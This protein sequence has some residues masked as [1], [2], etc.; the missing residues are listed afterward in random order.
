MVFI[1]QK[2][3]GQTARRC[4][5]RHSGFANKCVRRPM[6]IRGYAPRPRTSTRVL[7]SLPLLPGE[8]EKERCISVVPFIR[9]PYAL[10]NFDGLLDERMASIAD[11][12]TGA[13]YSTIGLFTERFL[14]DAFNVTYSFNCYLLTTNDRLLRTSRDESHVYNRSI[15]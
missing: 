15:L 12:V 6:E 13:K 2:S 7:F 8:R 4:P 9:R 10:G 5:A 11:G 3:T 14:I 1:G